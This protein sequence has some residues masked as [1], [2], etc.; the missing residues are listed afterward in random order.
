MAAGL[1]IDAYVRRI[2]AIHFDP[3]GGAPYWLE[4]A[5]SLGWDPRERVQSLHD[6]NLLGPM[7][8][9]ALRDRSVLDFVPKRRRAN[10]I[11][12]I[13]AETGG[14]TGRP[15]RTV[16]S[17]AEFYQ[18]FVEPFVIVAEHAGFPKGASWLWAGP[19]GP[20]IIGQAASACAEALGS[21]QPF[22]IDFDPRWFRKLPPDSLGRERYFQH[23]LDQALSVISAE[24]I[25]VLFTTP[26]MLARLAQDM[27]ATQRAR[28]RGVH[29]G[30]MRVEADLLASAQD[31]W[32]PNAVH[33]AG[34][35]NSLFGVCMEL[36]GSSDRT[37]R[38]Y[39]FGPRHQIRVDEAGRVWMS[40]LDETV[41]IAN[42]PERDCTSASSP[43]NHIAELGFHDGVEDPG[44]IANTSTP[45]N[46]GI[47]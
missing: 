21:P 46:L 6:L 29:Y 8:E 5:E 36:G 39:P 24:V 38:Y 32:F 42:L 44:P 28:I 31:D 15:K 45:S 10:L 37:L 13:T 34:Y 18:G 19:S 47:Y 27:T 1:D 30:G 33:L 35:G 40:R 12:G 4:R 26:V 22:C 2:I 23:L 14:A 11:G 25:E 9:D 3:E 41:L 43:P 7:D 16:F 17:R 20:H